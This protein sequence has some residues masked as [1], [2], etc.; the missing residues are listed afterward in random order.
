MDYAELFRHKFDRAERAIDELSDMVSMQKGSWV[1]RRHVHSKADLLRAPQ[2]ERVYSIQEKI[3]SDV[4]AWVQADQFPEEAR[5]AYRNSRERVYRRLRMVRKK[6]TQ[7][8]AF[9]LEKFVDFFDG[10][11]TTVMDLL[12]TVGKLVKLAVRMLA[13]PA[14]VRLLMSGD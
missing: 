9:G 11:V 2:F 13:G 1:F 14:P 3:G 4:M 10:F 5:E 8:P 12:P 7:R 6:I